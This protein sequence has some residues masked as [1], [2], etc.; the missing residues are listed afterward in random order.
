MRVIILSSQKNQSFASNFYFNK[1][2]L[3]QKWNVEE[4]TMKEKKNMPANK[5]KT[6]SMMKLQL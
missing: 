1:K 2:I 6:Y 5:E 3:L 4:I